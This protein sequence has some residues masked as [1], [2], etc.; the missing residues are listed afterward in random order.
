[1]R[2]H[3]DKRHAGMPRRNAPKLIRST[4]VFRIPPAPFRP[5][6]TQL[7]HKRF[8][9]WLPHI[10]IWTAHITRCLAEAEQFRV[11]HPTQAHAQLFSVKLVWNSDFGHGSSPREIAGLPIA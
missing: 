5:G 3:L 9:R 7:N 4:A 8:Q 6:L 1:M 10:C 2:G 11:G